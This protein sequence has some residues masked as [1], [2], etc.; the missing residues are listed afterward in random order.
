[1]WHCSCCG[2]GVHFLPAAV[3]TSALQV[4]VFSQL[5]FPKIQKPKDVSGEKKKRQ[6]FSV[7]LQVETI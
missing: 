6:C 5:T 4:F 2:S 7:S 3:V 1:M